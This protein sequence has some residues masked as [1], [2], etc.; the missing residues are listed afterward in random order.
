LLAARNERQL[1][2]FVGFAAAR[3]REATMKANGL[4]Q[5]RLLLKIVLGAVPIVAGL[6]KFTNLLTN[7][8]KYL[9]PAVS[10][11]VPA[12]TFM[13][14]VGVVEIAAGALVLFGNHRVA[15]VGAYLVAAWLLCIAVNLLAMGQFLDVAV[16]DF[17]MACG[18]Y[19]LAKLEEAG[20]RG[21]HD[22][23]ARRTAT[24]GGPSV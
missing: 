15:R 18:A 1:D 19:T 22:E 17:V 12:A 10:Q 14:V 9:N 24:A 2:S 7:W 23:P 6:D 3:P 5:A 16:R 8:E 20:V 11:L 13:R 4:D 21:A